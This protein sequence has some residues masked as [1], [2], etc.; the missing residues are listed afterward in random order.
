VGHL[1]SSGRV[2][3]SERLS[4]AL[5]E[6]KLSAEDELTLRWWLASVLFAQSRLTEGLAIA[7]VGWEQA[8]DPVTKARMAALVC[9]IKLLLLDPSFEETLPLAQEAALAANDPSAATIVN[10]LASRVAVNRLDLDEALRFATAAVHAAD[11]DRSGL[12]HRYQPIYFLALVMLDLVDKSAL[13]KYLS[14][15]RRRAEQTGTGWS[16]S[17]FLA[18][19]SLVAQRDGRFDDALADARAAI[20]ISEES[21]IYIG[22]V[23]AHAVCAIVFVMRGDFDSAREAIADGQVIL[24]RDLLQFGSDILA[25]AE[26]ELRIAEGDVVGGLNFSLDTSEFYAAIGFRTAMLS[27]FQPVL[28]YGHLLTREQR[29]EIG[30]RVAKLLDTSGESGEYLLKP[31]Q[32][33]LE[34]HRKGTIESWHNAIK[35]VDGEGWGFHAAMVRA[36]A[37]CA[38]Q[39]AEPEAAR[40]FAVDANERLGKATAFAEQGRLAGLLGPRRARKGNTPALSRTERSV[41]GLLAEGLSNRAIADQTGQSVRTVEAHVSSIL[42]KLNVTSR[43]RVAAMLRN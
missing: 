2:T 30:K 7:N 36:S 3:D 31:A 39:A 8:R 4:F 40:L 32:A 42:R 19:S 5:L 14:L 29:M 37:A 22:V 9:L 6:Q 25:A 26:A 13:V 43:A 15:G 11:E 24:S 21:G 35:A 41:A 34:A 18:T 33:V 1:G 38:L 27:S 10:S 12:A 23:F 16:N 20:A 28:F 17:L